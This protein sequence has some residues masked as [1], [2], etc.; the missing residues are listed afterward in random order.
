MTREKVRQA[1]RATQKNY[2]D[3]ER[4]VNSK[5]NKDKNSA[6]QDYT[7]ISHQVTNEENTGQVLNNK[8]VVN[9]INRGG[10]G[11]H[12]LRRNPPFALNFSLQ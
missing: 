9:V 1:E 4:D 10:Q 8:Q 6:I 2:I 7:D 3:E 11:R 5:I 12:Y